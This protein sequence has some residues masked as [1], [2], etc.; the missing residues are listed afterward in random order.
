MELKK[1]CFEMCWARFLAGANRYS[2]AEVNG[3]MLT[4]HQLRLQTLITSNYWE[5]NCYFEAAVLY[6]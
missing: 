2:S 4:L 5:T 3:A 6:T 1:V